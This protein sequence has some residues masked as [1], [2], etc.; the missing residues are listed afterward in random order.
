MNYIQHKTVEMF[1]ILQEWHKADKPNAP[2]RYKQ[3]ADAAYKAKRSKTHVMIN[4]EY[5]T[6]EE[7][8]LDIFY[9]CLLDHQA[10][11]DEKE[12]KCGW[13]P[14]M[15]P[16]AIPAYYYEGYLVFHLHVGCG[17]CMT[18]EFTK[19]VPKDVP[20]YTYDK[21]SMLIEHKYKIYKKHVKKIRTDTQEAEAKKAELT[22]TLS[23]V[24]TANALMSIF[25]LKLDEAS[26]K[27]VNKWRKELELAKEKLR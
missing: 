24:D 26:E 20:I 15:T 12:P 25:G 18:C 27:K 17:S 10:F 5:S 1:K 22:K 8:L 21:L 23:A 3:L 2:S 4:T 16:Y 9:H 13:L 19:R 11:L 14:E 6:E 7:R